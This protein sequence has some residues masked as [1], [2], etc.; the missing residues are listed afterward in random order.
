MK[1]L[2]DPL[3]I[4]TSLSLKKMKF[5]LSV[6]GKI[7][8]LFAQEKVDLHELLFLWKQFT[9]LM[10]IQLGRFNRKVSTLTLMLNKVLISV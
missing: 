4:T 5:S 3:E 8:L 9:N 2:T 6:H 1:T 7:D 10:S